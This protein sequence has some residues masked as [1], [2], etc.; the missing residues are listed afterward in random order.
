VN[1]LTKEE[2]LCRKKLSDQ[3]FTEGKS[4]IK[5]P[6]RI[7]YFLDDQTKDD[8][9]CKVLFIVSKKRF[10]RAVDRN[11]LKRRMREAYRL[12]KELIFQ[13]GFRSSTVLLGINYIGKEILDYEI[14]YNEMIISL[15]KLVILIDTERQKIS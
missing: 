14:I 12:N 1:T 4:F 9:A 10:K 2:R 7:T 11:L 8:I 13:S 6:L 3:L 5:F 15:N